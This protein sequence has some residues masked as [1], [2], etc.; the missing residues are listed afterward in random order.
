MPTTWNPLDKTANAT[1]SNGNLTVAFSSANGGVRSIYSESIGK[2]YWETTFNSGSGPA[3]GIANSSAI[4]NTAWSTNGVNAALY[5]NG[6]TY[7]NG[8][9]QSGTGL[10]LLLS[11]TFGIAVDF[12]AQRIW[13]R[14][15]TDGGNWNN[16]VAN[17]PATNVGGVN[18]AVLGTP[19]F[20]FA[21]SGGL[22]TWTTNFGATAFVGAVPSGF[23]VG[24]GPTVSIGRAMILA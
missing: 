9:T 21:V 2:W 11:K 4:L 3:F 14:N 6:S 10:T 22:N 16:N 19:L 20:A 18:I 24:F 15:A 13:A 7:V 8:V 17:N 1:L 12:I 23:S 5:Y